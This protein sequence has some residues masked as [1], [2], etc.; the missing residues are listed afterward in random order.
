MPWPLSVAPA[1]L[2]PRQIDG[3]VSAYQ[4]LHSS[5]FQDLY[6]RLPWQ[7]GAADN[8]LGICR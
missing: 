2:S 8:C 1:G 3:L 4:A 5:A 6:I 7:S